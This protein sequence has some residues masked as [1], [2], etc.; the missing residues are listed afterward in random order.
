MQAHGFALELGGHHVALDLLDHQHKDQHL[1]RQGDAAGDQ[2]KNGV[3]HP[4]DDGAEVGDEVHDKGNDGKQQGIPQSDDPEAAVAHRSHA[5]GDEHPG[6]QILPG[7]AV[8]F[9]DH[10]AH[11]H[12]RPLGQG[13]DAV[14][15]H[16]GAVQHEIDDE[17][18]HHHHIKQAGGGIHQPVEHQAEQLGQISVRLAHQFGGPVQHRLGQV[19][20]GQQLVQAFQQPVKIAGIG[21]Q[22]VDDAGDLLHRIGDEQHAQPNDQANHA[23]GRHRHGDAPGDPLSKGQQVDDG[24][25]QIGDDGRQ[26]KQHHHIP[27]A[28]NDGHKGHQQDHERQ[29]TGIF[30]GRRLLHSGFFLM[31]P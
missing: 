26:K 15:D 19:P 12:R 18:D 9:R 11:P 5:Q 3:H 25:E 28:V 17:D 29:Q 31:I 13:A 14:V 24:T 27:E 6:A 30:H 2:G 1:Y 7:V 22:V 21:H 16:P 20:G 4:G 10:P 23:Q 8:G